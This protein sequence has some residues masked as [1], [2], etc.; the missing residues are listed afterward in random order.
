ML[1]EIAI[2]VN[3]PQQGHLKVSFFGPFYGA[4]VIFELDTPNYQYAFVTSYNRSY[5]WLLSRTPQISSELQAHFIHTIKT[6]G[7]DT[8][9]LI[10]VSH[11]KSGP[12][13]EP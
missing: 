13:H 9:E 4:Y 6:L 3:K 8:T 7:F 2:F 1:R 12:H 11:S 5:L 10:F